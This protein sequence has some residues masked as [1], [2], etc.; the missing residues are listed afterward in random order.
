MYDNGIQLH[1][2]V[3]ILSMYASATV[4]LW[5]AK[6][7]DFHLSTSTY[8]CNQTGRLA[9]LLSNTNQFHATI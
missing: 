5:S 2:T 8:Q 9:M 7:S 3:E 4:F 6:F 1:K